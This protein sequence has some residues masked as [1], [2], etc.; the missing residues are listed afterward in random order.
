M[1]CEAEVDAE[2]SRQ[3]PGSEVG[4]S[5]D[6]YYFHVEVSTEADC[7]KIPLRAE[8]R[9]PTADGEEVVRRKPG[10]V[11]LSDGATGYRMQLDL[12][13]GE[14]LVSWEVNLTDCDP[15]T[16]LAPE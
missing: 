11:R 13:S 15:C 14:E 16:L 3:E 9:G 6:R 4:G 7:A 1:E 8:G 2:L 10:R 12:K 5:G